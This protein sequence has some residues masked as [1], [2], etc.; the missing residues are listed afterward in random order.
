MFEDTFFPGDDSY[1][2]ITHEEPS[3]ELRWRNQ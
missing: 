2:H 1:R 3:A